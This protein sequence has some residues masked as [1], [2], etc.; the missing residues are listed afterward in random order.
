MY[1][2]LNGQYIGYAEDSFTPSDFELTPYLK[3]GENQ[4]SVEVFQHSKASWVEDQDFFRFTGIFRPVVLYAIPTCHLFDIWAKTDFLNSKGLLSLRIKTELSDDRKYTVSYQLKDSRGLV[5]AS[6]EKP[7]EKEICF[8]TVLL[9]DILPYSWDNPVLYPLLIEV[10]DEAGHTVEC[11]SI[12][13]GYRHI[14]IKGKVIYLNGKRLIICGVNRHEWSPENGRAI[15]L[16]EMKRD[17]GILKRNHINSVRTCHYPDSIP[18][19]SL[20]DENGIYLVAETNLESH[21]SWQKAGKAESSWNVPGDNEEWTPLVLD[22]AISN[23]ETFKNHPS[24]LFWSLGNE[25]YAGSGIIAMNE[26]FKKKDDT[27]L[28]HYEGVFWRPELKSCVSDVESEMYTSPDN[29]RKYFK[30]DGSKPFLLCE[31]MHSMGN[32]LGGFTSYDALIDEYESYQG[33]WIWDFIDQALYV[34]NKGRKVLRYGGDF[35]EKATD[36]EFSANG[37]V[38]ADRCEKP[39]MNEVRHVYGNRLRRC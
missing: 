3:E 22:R 11:T 34:E 27:R 13:T 6:D 21:G 14:E 16:E 37:I 15:S 32:S 12:N 9:D 25:S 4:L 5:L 28:V 38:F 24:I 29:I 19:Y 36:Y 7:A 1:L 8:D 23:F 31:Y 10:K 39:A 17:I 26:Y 35:M 20:C 33:G 18:W 30:E 2:Y